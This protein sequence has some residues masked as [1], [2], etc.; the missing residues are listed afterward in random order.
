VLVVQHLSNEHP[1]GVA[2]AG[3]AAGLD[4]IASLTGSKRTNRLSIL[5]LAQRRLS[6][7]N[8]QSREANMF[9]RLLESSP[10][11]IWKWLAFAL[12]LL[13]PGSFIVLAVMGLIRHC[14]R[15]GGQLLARRPWYRQLVDH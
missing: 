13:A 4:I 6:R 15:D 12:V 2:L 11:E 3:P 8:H 5:G 1:C 9:N 7:T 10:R 14:V